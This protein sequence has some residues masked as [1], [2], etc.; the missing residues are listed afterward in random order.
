MVPS[1]ILS[2]IRGKNINSV[3][4]VYDDPGMKCFTAGVWRI[5]E[6]KKVVLHSHRITGHYYHHRIGANRERDRRESR[7]DSALKL[8]IL[9]RISM[10]K[11]RDRRLLQEGKRQ[12]FHEILAQRRLFADLNGDGR[13]FV[14]IFEHSSGGGVGGNAHRMPACDEFRNFMA[15]FT[16]VGSMS[17][18]NTSQMCSRCGH[19]LEFA[20]KREIRTKVCKSDECTRRSTADDTK[21]QFFY[22]DR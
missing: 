12:L 13:D 15:E 7:H 17:G 2:E 16:L 18:Y 21:S 4:A 10:G 14:Q 6:G 3:P 9:Q 5:L 1:D 22:V 8:T 11:A 19:R 20:N